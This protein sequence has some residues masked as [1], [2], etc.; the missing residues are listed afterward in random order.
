MASRAPRYGAERAT[1]A[2]CALGLALTLAATPAFADPIGCLVGPS[3]TNPCALAGAP[4]AVLGAIAAP[5]IFV[6]AA[7]TAARELHKHTVER[8]A[9]A[10][11]G[12]AKKSEPE[13]VAL[14][15]AA[16]DPYRAPA[17]V[18]D[19]PHKPSAA[20]QFNETATNV[21]TVVTGAAVLGAAIATI[22][23]SAK[24]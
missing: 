17:G 11:G 14:V 20:F 7:V 15:P 6:G 16:I 21:A 2:A 10:T 24:K 22:V 18:P 23:K 8:A 9:A 19:A 13:K 5:A 3:D 1:R 4:A 12:N